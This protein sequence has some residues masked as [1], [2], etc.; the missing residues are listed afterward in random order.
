VAHRPEQIALTDDAAQHA[1]VIEDGGRPH[2][3]LVQ[4]PA[5]LAETHLLVHHH[6]RGVHEIGDRERSGHPS[7]CS[8][9]YQRFSPRRNR[10]GIRDP[11]RPEQ[12]GIG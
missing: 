12:W 2:L 5:G 6:R 4:H 1:V 10:G 3:V 8:S 11:P 9:E 7:K